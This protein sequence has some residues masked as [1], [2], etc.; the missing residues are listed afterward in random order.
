MFKSPKQHHLLDRTKKEGK[1]HMKNDL[2]YAEDFKEGETFNLGI[3]NVTKEEIVDFA[4]KYDPFPFHVD[5]AKA[6]ETIFEG[7]ISSGWLTAL[8]WLRMM[9]EEFLSYEVTLGSPGHE[10]M[11]W[12][13]PVRPGDT[14]N[15]SIT[16]KGV[17]ISKSKPDLGF[18]RYEALLKN[19]EQK[20]VFS[21]TSTLIIKTRQSAS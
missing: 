18:I 11:L 15:G 5:E 2:Y 13:Q 19:Q 7:I 20:C 10:E 12:P 6:K 9:H 3:Y 17:K 16:I 21:T 14:L 8:I 1:E 4:E